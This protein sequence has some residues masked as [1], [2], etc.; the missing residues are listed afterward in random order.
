MRQSEQQIPTLSVF[1]RK[2]IPFENQG[3][4]YL[5]EPEYHVACLHILLNRD[6]VQ[7][8]LEYIYQLLKVSFEY[9][10]S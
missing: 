2:G 3:K 7:P 5:T 9:L 8:Y 4:R 10:N 6:E 1:N